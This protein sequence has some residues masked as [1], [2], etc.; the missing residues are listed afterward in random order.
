MNRTPKAIRH[1]HIILIMLFVFVVSLPT[2][3]FAWSNDDPYSY[4]SKQDKL[5]VYVTP[6]IGW[7]YTTASD[8][9]ETYSSSALGMSYSAS[10]DE[11]YHDSTFAGGLAVGYDLSRKTDVPIRA[12][13]E[14]MYRT[15]WKDDESYYWG[16][17][18]TQSV[19][20]KFQV[21]TLFINTYL[22]IP[23]GTAFTPYVGAGAGVAFVKTKLDDSASFLDIYKVS[24]SSSETETNFAWNVG[25]GAAYSFNEHLAL[26][27]NYRYADFGSGKAS[28]STT[29]PIFEHVKSKREADV[30]S[31]EVLMGLRF[32]M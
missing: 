3:S 21:Q 15:D 27:V 22:D 7:S 9:K 26:D 13:V 32:T 25:V 28:A 19:E 11:D 2:L 31:H 12:E 6:K 18:V 10:A 20:S 30:T 24:G 4:M 23:T 16:G 17:G 29:D 5:G 14:Y 1:C 8:V